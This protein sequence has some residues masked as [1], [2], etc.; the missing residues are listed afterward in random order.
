MG[1]LFDCL[2]GIYTGHADDRILDKWDEARREIWH[3]VINPISTENL[4][5][6]YQYS[7]PDEALEK[8]PFLSMMKK[9]EAKKRQQEGNFADEEENVSF[10]GSLL[11]SLDLSDVANTVLAARIASVAIRYDT[12][13]PQGR[14]ENK[15]N[16]YQLA[17]PGHNSM[18]NQS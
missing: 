16:W 14:G 5:R 8:D 13:L 6:L 10:W 3:A 11:F 17:I 1:G 4:K 12:A 15:W 2:V 7:G 18:L 9:A